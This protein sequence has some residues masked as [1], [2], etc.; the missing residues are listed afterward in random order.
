M[1]TGL[2]VTPGEPGELAIAVDGLLDDPPWAAAVGARARERAHTLW[3]QRESA[4]RM[5]DLLRMLARIAPPRVPRSGPRMH[6]AGRVAA[7]PSA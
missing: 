7:A 5:G 3:P 6:L 1:Q 4:A 2:L